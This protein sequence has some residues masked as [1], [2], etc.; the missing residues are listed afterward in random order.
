MQNVIAVRQI[1][2]PSEAEIVSFATDMY[3][4]KASLLD[5]N[6]IIEKDPSSASRLGLSFTAAGT[7]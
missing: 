2:E 3:N 4:G 6:C 5:K 7:S 1:S